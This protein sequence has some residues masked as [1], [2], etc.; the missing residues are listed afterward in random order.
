M[1]YTNDELATFIYQASLSTY[2]GGGAYEKIVERPGFLEMAYKQGGWYYRDSY[3]GY[4]RSSGSEL[5]RFQDQIVWASNYC[6]GMV[7]G[8]EN[9]AD[10]T[11]S[12]LKKA[13]ISKPKDKQS[14]RGPDNFKDEVWE[15]RYQQIGD[16]ISFSGHEEIYHNGIVVFSQDIIGGLI[17]GK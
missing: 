6:G 13:I 17:K 14:F 1:A 8:Y 4:Y 3:T 10:D 2:V 7:D 15:Y 16:V 11:F 5:V 9:L 12:F